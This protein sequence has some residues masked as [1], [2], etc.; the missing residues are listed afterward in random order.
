MSRG[1]T[2]SAEP[3][4]SRKRWVGMPAQERGAV[5]PRERLAQIVPGQTTYEA[6]V[7]L[8]GRPSEE[9]EDLATP[10]R[11]TLIYRGRR[12]VPQHRWA[13]GWLA[14]VSHWD[15]EHHEV[16]IALDHGV[17]QDIQ[18]RVRRARLSAP[19]AA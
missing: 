6:L 12:D 13:W 5:L 7:H 4:I 11:Q 15:V 9:R 17:V 3:G 1:I 8:C 16:E 19:D 10:G 2:S 14:T 18:V